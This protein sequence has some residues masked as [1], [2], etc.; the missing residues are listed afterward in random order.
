MIQII[1]RALWYQCS[2]LVGK[3]NHLLVTFWFRVCVALLQTS[4][5]TDILFYIPSL[6][7]T[8]QIDH[9]CRQNKIDQPVT[10]AKIHI[11]SEKQQPLRY[12]ARILHTDQSKEMELQ[13]IVQTIWAI[14]N[15]PNHRAQYVKNQFDK[16]WS[17]TRF[18]CQP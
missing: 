11:S 12:V 4:F 18:F 16:V 5:A 10:P 3:Q 6:I 1:S 2:I 14:E 7:L 17:I 13:A 8:L 9:K 15:L